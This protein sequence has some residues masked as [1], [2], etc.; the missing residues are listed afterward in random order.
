[1]LLHKRLHEF[2]LAREIVKQSAFRYTRTAGNSVEREIA[3]AGFS[4]YIR[5]CSKD[6][7]A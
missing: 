5:C 3:G 6:F 7:I 4:R 2:C 1:M